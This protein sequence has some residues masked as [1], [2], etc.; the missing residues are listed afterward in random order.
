MPSVLTVPTIESERAASPSRSNQPF[1]HDR[2]T[3]EQDHIGRCER[4]QSGVHQLHPGRAALHD[5]LT[6][7]T[8][9]F[10]EELCNRRVAGSV[11][12]NRHRHLFGHLRQQ[13]PNTAVHQVRCGRHG[14]A[15]GYGS[16]PQRLF[17]FV[18]NGS[19]DGHDKVVRASVT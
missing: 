5:H 4:C 6:D 11:L 7:V 9:D 1:A 17:G 10:F 13:A 3:G 2:V 14:Y 16:A 19:R 18:G 12:D 8:L 15:H